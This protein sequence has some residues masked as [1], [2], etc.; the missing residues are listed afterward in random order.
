M[1]RMGRAM[2]VSYP[3][4]IVQ[5]VHNRQVVFAAPRDFERYLEALAEFK[6]IYGVKVYACCLMTNPVHLLVAPG[7]EIAGVGRLMKRLAVCQARYH[8]GREGRTGTLWESRYKSS[9]VDTDAYLLACSRYS[10]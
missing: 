3:H 1:P 8:N 4:H 5:R 2:L 9:P 6:A 7:E 10:S